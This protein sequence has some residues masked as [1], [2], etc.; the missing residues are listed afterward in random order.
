MV[1]GEGARFNSPEDA[2][3]RGLYELGELILRATICACQPYVPRGI[4]LVL[5]IDR[6]T[7]DESVASETMGIWVF[8]ARQIVDPGPGGG[9]ER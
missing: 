7:M 3:G 1:T 5:V 2:S 6:I 4:G 8:R 9:L